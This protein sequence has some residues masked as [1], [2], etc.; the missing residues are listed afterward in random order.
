MG[1]PTENLGDVVDFIG[2]G[3]PSKKNADYYSGSILGQ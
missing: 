3:T 1:W 2:G